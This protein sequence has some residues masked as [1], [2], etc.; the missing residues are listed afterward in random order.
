MIVDHRMPSISPGIL[1]GFVSGR[2]GINGCAG[3]VCGHDEGS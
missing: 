1:G 3:C 2:F